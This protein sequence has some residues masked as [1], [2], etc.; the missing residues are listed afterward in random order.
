MSSKGFVAEILQQLSDRID[1]NAD[2]IRT[3]MQQIMQG[4][5]QPAQIGAFLLGLRVKRESITELTVAA[6][7]MRSFA[8]QVPVSSRQ[9]LIDTCGTGGD[10]KNTFNVSTTVAFVVAAA[11][12]RVAKHGGRS[13]S[14][15]CGSADVLE[16][17]GVP[18]NLSSERIGVAIDTLGIG[19]MFAQHHHPAMKHVAAIRKELGTRTI[20][21]VLG[22]LTNPAGAPHQLLGVFSGALVEPLVRVLDRLGS[23]RAL[24]VSGTDGLD[25]LSISAPTLVGEI[26]KGNYTEKLVA[27]EKFGLKSSPIEALKVATLDEAKNS[28]LE[29]LSDTPGAKRD[30]VLLNAGA[31]LYVCGIAASFVEGIDRARA[32]LAN[33]AAQ[34]KLE[35]LVQFR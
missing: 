15:C 10:A 28:I 21:N 2:Q 18:L 11:G 8:M 30:I 1:L 24:V 4:E 35:A 27:P 26:S 9:H 19:F 22:P 5:W 6:E 29:V 17:L 23:K 12:G 13:V 20:F 25:E 7:V 33:G 32:V 3:A 16:A 34:K 31:A 14:S